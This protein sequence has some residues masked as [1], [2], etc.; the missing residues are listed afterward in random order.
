MG[1]RAGSIDPGI[2]LHL[3]GAGMALDELADGLDHRSGLVAMSGT[4]GGARELEA[5]SVNGDPSATLALRMFTRRAAAG[6]A[7]AATTLERLD[8]LVF[9]GGIGENSARLR[10]GITER[11]AF[12]GVPRVAQAVTE[13]RVLTTPEEPVAVLRVEAREDLAI[14]RAVERTMDSAN[15]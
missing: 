9:T 5:A 1:S 11:L 13:D 12:I 10:A 3:L 4:T 7:A 15:R 8:A 6:I 2:L 14:A